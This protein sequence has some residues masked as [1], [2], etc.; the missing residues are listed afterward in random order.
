MIKQ[1]FTR[2]IMF[3]TYGVRVVRTCYMLRIYV[4]LGYREAHGASAISVQGFAVWYVRTYH[5][6]LPGS[7]RSISDM[8]DMRRNPDIPLE[9]ARVGFFT[10]FGFLLVSVGHHD[11]FVGYRVVIDRVRTRTLSLLSNTT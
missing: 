5:T 7:Y 1:Q 6:H 2:C 10:H 11:A 3:D 9:F 4:L 8:V